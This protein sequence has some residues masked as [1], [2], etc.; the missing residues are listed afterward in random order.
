MVSQLGLRDIWREQNIGQ[1]EYTYH[2]ERHNSNSRID[3]IWVTK[4]IMNEVVDMEF[5]PRFLSDHKAIGMVYKDG[6]EKKKGDG[7]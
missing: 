3:M 6:K 7:D 5:Y 2:S 1:R 4:R